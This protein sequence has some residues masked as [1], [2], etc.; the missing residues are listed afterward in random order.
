MRHRENAYREHMDSV[1]PICLERAA[2][3]HPGIQGNPPVAR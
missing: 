2:E 1:L 3:G